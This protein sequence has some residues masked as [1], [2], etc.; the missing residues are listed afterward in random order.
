MDS[1]KLDF[2]KEP[3]KLELSKGFRGRIFIQVYERDTLKQIN[4]DDML[5]IKIMRSATFSSNIM[6]SYHEDIKGF[7][8]LINSELTTE[9]GEKEAVIGIVNQI[10][11][12]EELHKAI[13]IVKEGE[14]NEAP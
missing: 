12:T 13:W 2:T 1:Y 4:E 14:L 6:S 9:E 7:K 11:G 8:A 10:E 5:Y 3:L